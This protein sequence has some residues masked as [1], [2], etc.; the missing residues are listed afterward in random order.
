MQC[1]LSVTLHRK[2]CVD[3]EIGIVL[4][5]DVFF[6]SCAHALLSIQLLKGWNMKL[7]PTKSIQKYLHPTSLY[8]YRVQKHSP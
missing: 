5:I 2:Y 4:K 8:F 1:I 7:T 3:Y 6:Y